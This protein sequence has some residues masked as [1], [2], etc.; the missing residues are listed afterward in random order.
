MKKLRI[1]LK[2]KMHFA[3]VENMDAYH[4]DGM[5]D[6]IVGRPFCRKAC[7]KARRFDGMI[8]IYKGND[9]VTYQMA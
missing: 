9:N 3:V 6:I 1:R 2:K 4:D 5:G 7:V 8:T